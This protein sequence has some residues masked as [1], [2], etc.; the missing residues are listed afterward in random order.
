[1][2]RQTVASR[3]HQLGGAHVAVEVT[4]QECPSPTL[5]L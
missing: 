2:A 4:C 3:L 5:A 1:L